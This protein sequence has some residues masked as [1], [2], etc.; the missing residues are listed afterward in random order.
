MWKC[1]T[2]GA[3]YRGVGT[4][5]WVIPK[6]Y[7]FCRLTPS[8]PHPNWHGGIGTQGTRSYTPVA[9]GCAQSQ[10]RQPPPTPA[11]TSKHGTHLRLQVACKSKVGDL[12]RG[13]GGGR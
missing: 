1:R 8:L 7:V 4:G 13:I 5:A 9:A 2:S 12:Q 6:P 3:V 10:S 11:A